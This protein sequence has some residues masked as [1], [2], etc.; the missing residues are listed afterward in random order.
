MM[1]FFCVFLGAYLMGSIPFGLLFV[2]WAGGGDVRTVGSGN[3]G[4][5]NVLR[6]GKKGIAVATL[7]ADF[8]K[9]FLA[10]YG[11]SCLSFFFS[12]TLSFEEGSLFLLKAIAGIGAVL[13]H[14]FPLWLKFKG[15]KGV[16]TALGTF[17]GFFPFLCLAVVIVWGLIA[18]VSRTSSLAALG[19]FL[20]APLMVFFLKG[21]A[22]LIFYGLC[23]GGL[24]FY[25]H[26][27]NISK[28]LKGNELSFKKKTKKE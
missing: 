28:L 11:V 24:I 22:F 1:T 4:A 27:S 7:C 26:R 9:G 17:L 16:A 18:K 23:I 8:L 2:K 20:S 14:I 12:N 10:V 5:T 13:G 19:A 21:P 15:G 25:T 3:I 6:T